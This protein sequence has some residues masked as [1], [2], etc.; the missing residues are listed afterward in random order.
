[1]DMEILGGRIL[2]ASDSI[3]YQAARLSVENR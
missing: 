3:F 2:V 1:M